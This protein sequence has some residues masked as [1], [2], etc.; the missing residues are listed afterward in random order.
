MPERKARSGVG[1][2]NRNR[3]VAS[4]KTRGP[5]ELELSLEAREWCSVS[6]PAAR[7][8]KQP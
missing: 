7:E 5:Q 8:S 6:L 4:R 2:T 3:P 1:C